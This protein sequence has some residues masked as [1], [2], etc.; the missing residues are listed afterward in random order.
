MGHTFFH[1]DSE[2]AHWNSSREYAGGNTGYRPGIKR[3]YFPVAPLDS[4]HDIRAAMCKTPEQ[5][6]IQ[7]EVH[8]H[9]VAHAGQCEIGT[10]STSL[11]RKADELLTQKY[12]VTHV[13][14]RNGQTATSTPTPHVAT[15]R[16]PTPRQP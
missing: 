3:G 7:V 5:V 8:H 11:T 15:N 1:I 6:G 9:E 10:T 16:T 12:V 2:E 14:H 4:L 13:A